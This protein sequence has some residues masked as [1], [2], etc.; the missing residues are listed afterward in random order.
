M[1]NIHS[2]VSL[3]PHDPVDEEDEEDEEGDVGEGLEGLD[4]GVEELS[5]GLTLGQQLHQSHGPVVEAI[6]VS[7]TSL[8]YRCQKV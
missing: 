7:T 1:P 6:N 3:H 5:D 2:S 4:E 8:A